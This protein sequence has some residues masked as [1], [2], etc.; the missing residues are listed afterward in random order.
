MFPSAVLLRGGRGAADRYRCVWGALTEFRPH[1]VCPARGCLCSP[2]LHCSGSRLLYRERALRC[3]RFQF[4]GPPQKCGCACV[5]CL[6]GLSGSGS[7]ELDRPGS[8]SPGAG[9]PFP[10]VAPAS[11]SAH[12]WL[13]FVLRSCGGCRSSRISGSLWIETGGLFAVWEGMSSLGPSLPLSPPPCLLPPAGMG[14]STAGQLFSG[15]SQSLCFAKGQQC[16][17]AG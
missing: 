2:R 8:L 12:K 10:S 4:S 7:P 17:L 14:L 11:I 16:V 6:P 1:W 9:R 15:V 5:L 3:M 13:V